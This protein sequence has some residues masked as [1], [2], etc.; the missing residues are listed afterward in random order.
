VG[1]QKSLSF[2]AAGCSELSAITTFG[3][4]WKI[5]SVQLNQTVRII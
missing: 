3:H 2:G 4:R 5:V 1:D